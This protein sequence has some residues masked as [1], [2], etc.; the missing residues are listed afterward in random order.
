MSEQL[1]NIQGRWACP[2][3]YAYSGGGR[4]L[5]ATHTVEVGVSEPLTSIQGGGC[6]L[7]AKHTGRWAN[8]NS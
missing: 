5:T 4:V 6:V 2:N 3:S 8:V 7:T 1:R